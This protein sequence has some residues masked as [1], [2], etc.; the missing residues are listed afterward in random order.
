MV[1]KKYLF[2]EYFYKSSTSED[3]V[4]HF[5]NAA[6]K[7]IRKFSLNKK[8]NIIDIGSND[9]IALMFYKKLRFSN[10]FWS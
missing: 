9:G 5:N 10:L 4:N 7:Y 2:T 1:D 3:L 8:S 6:K